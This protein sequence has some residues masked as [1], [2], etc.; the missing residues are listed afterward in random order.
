MATYHAADEAAIRQRITGLFEAVSAMDLDGVKLAYA[1]DMVSFDIE[2]PLL[3]V[4]AE[5]KWRNWTGFFTVFQRPVG[6]ETRDLEITAGDDVAFAHSL[7][8]ITGTL[9]NGKRVDYW[10]RWTA[11][12]RKTDG[13]WLIAHDHVSVPLDMASGRALL[14]LKP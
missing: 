4:G 3:H 14:D 10:V 6:Y 8:R 13:T 5:A 2:P 7:N 11:C 9:Q 1:P 12:L